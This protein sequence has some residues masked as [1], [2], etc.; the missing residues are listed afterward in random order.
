MC[1]HSSFSQNAFTS[2]GKMHH[3]VE[4]ATNLQFPVDK[5]EKPSLRVRYALKEQY[6][7]IQKYSIC[8]GKRK[9]LAENEI[10]HFN[11]AVQITFFKIFQL[12]K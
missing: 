1:Q 6:Q 7:E 4:E 3:R 12:L 10:R 8:L 5:L 9:L 11:I 2:C